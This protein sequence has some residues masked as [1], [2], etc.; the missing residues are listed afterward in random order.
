MKYISIFLLLFCT[1]VFCG[2]AEV[3]CS[4]QEK[5]ALWEAPGG[6][7]FVIGYPELTVK[8][9][10][11][12]PTR[13]NPVENGAELIYPDGIVCRLVSA[14]DGVKA[15]LQNG[16]AVSSF[17]W[18][19]FVGRSGTAGC[20]WQAGPGAPD[21]LPAVAPADQDRE[22]V[23]LNEKRENFRYVSADGIEWSFHVVP[24]MLRVRFSTG[25]HASCGRAYMFRFFAELD[26]AQEFQL[27]IG[28]RETAEN[29]VLVDR[30]GQAATKEFP[31]KVHSD[32][33]LRADLAD[34]AEYFSDCISPERDPYGGLPGSRE[35][36][37]LR[38]TGYFHLEKCNGRDVLVTPE[39]NVFFHLAVCSLVPKEDFTLVRGRESLYEWLP[40]PDG[41]FATAFV[42][43]HAAR[44]GGA[45]GPEDT[46][47]SFYLTNWIRKYGRAYELPLWRT[48]QI[49]RLKKWGF[50]SQG[51][52][53]EPEELAGELRFP[54]TRRLPIET[55]A[56]LAYPFQSDPFDPALAK[57]LEERLKPLLEANASDPWLIGYFMINEPHYTQILTRLPRQN[58]KIAAKRELV[59]FLRERYGNDVGAFNAAWKSEVRSFDEAEEAELE[60]RSEQSAAD[61]AAFAEYFL[62]TYF[63]LVHDILRKYDSN[64]LLL[65]PRFLPSVTREMEYS[66]RAAGK[67]C[68]TIAVNYYGETI[69]PDYLSHLNQLSGRPL[70]LSEWSYGNDEQGLAGGVVNVP[71]QKARGEAYRHYLEQAAALPYVVGSQYFQYLDQALTGRWHQKYNGE[72]M[73]TGLVNVADRPYREFLRH[74]IT[75]N[76]EIY[77]VVL[78]NRAPFRRDLE[79]RE[80]R[81]LQIA[82]AL[83][84]LQ[85]DGAIE[86]YPARPAYH[87]GPENSTSGRTDSGSADFYF[88]Y[89]DEYLYVYAAVADD[90]PFG[91]RY[92]GD[93]LWIGD[94]VE[95][96]LGGETPDASG[97]LK[98]KDRQL[99]IAIKEKPEYFWH[100]SF[101]QF[102][103]QAVT[104]RRPGG[105]ALE[106]AVPW[107]AIDFEP[108]SGR[109]LRFDFGYNN[110]DSLRDRRQFMFSGTNN[111]GMLRDLWGV[112]LLVD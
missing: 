46:G 77:D 57:N 45:L 71:D 49:E 93:Q 22:L 34:E 74:V 48:Q 51:A 4:F 99:V 14:P 94:C 54:Y 83:P 50:N 12:S 86:H 16:A 29:V 78:G 62:D 35:K 111:N 97:V 79:T 102:P 20:R 8:G 84:G 33:E 91:N 2:A 72:N 104:L 69:D 30:Y 6:T 59:R 108:A 73:N 61:M 25:W 11:V 107:K 21:A 95:L 92:A 1:I 7:R 44:S 24:E 40:E 31:G 65:G 88:A 37:Q 53:S 36:F 58:G 81:R 10:G 80:P 32:E 26:G 66:V 19:V 64:H 5:G 55:I 75:S 52:F 112:A 15:K 17:S 100:H 110:A 18:T 101:E 67:W 103:V 98:P 9:R 68:D 60:I 63:K 109:E 43:N 39:G 85:V 105:Y 42:D 23:F 27:V 96:F 106:V 56:P 41:E 76:Y 70:I 89:D 90:T 82:R 28:Q 38:K 87:L 3:K 13:M 47:V